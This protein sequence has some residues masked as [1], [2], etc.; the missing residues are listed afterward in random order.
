MENSIH[1]NL[2]D[3]LQIAQRVRQ[4]SWSLLPQL[5]EFTL[6]QFSGEL[7]DMCL[8]HIVALR[9]RALRHIRLHYVEGSRGATHRIQISLRSHFFK[10][11][12]NAI[13]HFLKS[14]SDETCPM[15]SVLNV[16]VTIESRM[17]WFSC[18][19]D[20]RRC[21]AP[22][23]FFLISQIY[24]T[25]PLSTDHSF[26]LFRKLATN[27]NNNS[28]NELLISCIRM[29]CFIVVLDLLYDH[30]IPWKI[31]VKRM[32]K[33]WHNLFSKSLQRKNSMSLYVWCIIVWR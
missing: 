17:V 7:G 16:W 12:P 2:I 30:L 23:T 9:C 28:A 11:S 31:K 27:G 29:V 18:C 6:Y 15:H 1:I 4:I 26:W 21:S 25:Y 10:F 20:K 22:A 3:G 32:V 19:C 5:K 14:S 13:L 8:L 24:R 33:I